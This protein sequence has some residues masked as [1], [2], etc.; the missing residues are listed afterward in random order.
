MTNDND[1]SNILIHY[2]IAFH[3]HVLNLLNYLKK[4][5]PRNNTNGSSSSSFKLEKEKTTTKGARKKVKHLSGYN[6]FV[7][8]KEVRIKLRAQ[9][10]DPNITWSEMIKLVGAK[11]KSM[12]DIDKEP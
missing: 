8:D 6:V 11:W 10:G 7:K 5:A 1:K 2:S 9:H 12:N 4:G 3:E